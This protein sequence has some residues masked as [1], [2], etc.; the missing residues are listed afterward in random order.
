MQTHEVLF[1]NALSRTMLGDVVGKTCWRVIQGQTDG[2]CSFCTN[3]RLV[4]ADGRP[5]APV[6]W[7]HFNPV[8]QRWFQLHDQAIPWDDGRLVRLEIALDV[9]EQK[10][11]EHSLRDSEERYRRL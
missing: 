11:L 3:P 7:E 8:L 2:P 1:I 6:V 5:A 9:T 4:E 10:R